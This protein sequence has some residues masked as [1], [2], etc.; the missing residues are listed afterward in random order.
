MLLIWKCHTICAVLCLVTSNS[1]W[2]HGLQPARFLCPWGFS[3]QEFWSGL[4]CP[5]P[6]DLPNPRIK[7]RPPALQADSL[8]TEPPGKPKNTGVS[9]LSLAHYL[10]R[11]NRNRKGDAYTWGK[12][13]EEACV[14][15]AEERPK[16]L[17][18]RESTCSW[19][20][21]FFW[22]TLL[23]LIDLI[24]PCPLSWPPFIF[25]VMNYFSKIK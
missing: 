14:W 25:N 15:V 10:H 9:I 13:I 4:P 22:S 2:P 6:G 19:G 3:R 21:E 17:M 8:L 18:G 23:F 20:G 7:P 24:I 12:P 11:A 1:L 5:P 16:N